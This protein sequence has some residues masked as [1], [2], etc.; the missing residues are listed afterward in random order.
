MTPV[1]IF[2]IGRHG[3][4]QKAFLVGRSK[5]LPASPLVDLIIFMQE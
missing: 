1:A 4:M 2:E 3:D 5:Y